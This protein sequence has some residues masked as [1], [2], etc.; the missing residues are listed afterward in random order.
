MEGMAA[1]EVE[2][3]AVGA[4]MG[5]TVEHLEDVCFGAPVCLS[6]SLPR[7][8]TSQGTSPTTDR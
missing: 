6:L 1:V 3:E 4:S 5:L 8:D 7:T 2:V